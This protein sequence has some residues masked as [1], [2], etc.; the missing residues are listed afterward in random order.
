MSE[1]EKKHIRTEF[2]KGKGPA[3]GLKDSKEQAHVAPEAP[4]SQA[5]TQYVGIDFPSKYLV[6]Q[7]IDPTKVGIRLLKGKDEKL[8]AELSYDNF[9]RKFAEI[10]R[11]VI[12]GIDPRELTI[13]DRL[14]VMLWEAINSYNKIAEI[15]MQCKSCLQTVTYQIDLSTLAVVELPAGFK[16]PCPITMSNGDIINMRLFRVKDEEKLFDVQKAGYKTWLYR[17]A[18]SI[19]DEKKSDWDKVAYLEELNTRDLALIRAFHEQ[20]YHGPKMEAMV[21]CPKCG[22]S[23]VAPVPF[24]LEFFFP[25]G[26]A[27]RKYFGGTV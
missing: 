10:I 6:Y 16:E 13:G 1:S 27:L 14:Y 11:N 8:I 7:G 5:S 19:I 17:F 2:G 9:E 12:V 15:E 23:E 24:R 22:A 3:V 25:Y 18:L 20:Y 26:K 21:E 4:A